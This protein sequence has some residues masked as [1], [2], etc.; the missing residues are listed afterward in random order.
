VGQGAPGAGARVGRRKQANAKQLQ[1]RSCR[2]CPVRWWTTV[3]GCRCLA[4]PHAS[5]ARSTARIGHE[6]LRAPTPHPRPALLL[7]PCGRG[8][9]GCGRHGNGKA[10]ASPWRPPWRWCGCACCVWRG[11][12]SRRH[13]AAAAGTAPA[14]ARRQRQ[15]SRVAPLVAG[16]VAAAAGAT[17][18]NGTRWGKRGGRCARTRVLVVGLPPRRARVTT[19][20]AAVAGP[21]PRAGESGAAAESVGCRHARLDGRRPAAAAAVDAR[22]RAADGRQ[23]PGRGQPAS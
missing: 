3:R 21:P 19:A 20:S 14:P 7:C 18:I 15:R 2:G 1:R 6:T 12:G 13:G 17:A 11:G 9:L 22:P 4:E 8:R 5:A 10:S 16:S 23:R